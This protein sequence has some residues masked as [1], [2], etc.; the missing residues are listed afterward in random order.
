MRTRTA[1]MIASRVLAIYIAFTSIIFSGELIHALIEGRPAGVVAESALP[2]G[3]ALGLAL[4]LWV[5][6][7]A[8]AD[9]LAGSA[10]GGA[11]EEDSPARAADIAAIAFTVAGLFIAAQALPLVAHA[12]TRL[13]IGE[14][15]GRDIAADLASAIARTTIGAALAATA[16]SLAKRL[17][18]PESTR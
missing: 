4:L 16:R 3:V 6:A 14:G 9:R 8:V 11:G 10:S 12:L 13:A 15:T 18:A 5:A 7:P 1:G 2:A 17:F